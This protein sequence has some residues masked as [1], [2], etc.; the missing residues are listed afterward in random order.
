M[1]DTLLKLYIK[2]QDLKSKLQDEEGQDLVEYALIVALISLAAVVGMQAL[3]GDINTAFNT[4]GNKL[5]TS[6]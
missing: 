2:F 3:A 5:S 6:I 4:V 1:K